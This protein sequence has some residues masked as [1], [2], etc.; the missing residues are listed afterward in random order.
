VKR[1]L[2]LGVVGA[3]AVGAALVAGSRWGARAQHAPTGTGSGAPRTE[4]EWLVGAVVRDLSELI[5]KAAGRLDG[6]GRLSVRVVQEDPRRPRAAVT[7]VDPQGSVLQSGVI[8][9]THF[10]WSP[11]DYQSWATVLLRSG[12]VVPSDSPGDDGSRLLEALLEPTAAVLHR[13]SEEVSESLGRDLRVASRHEDAAAVVGAFALRDAAGEFADTRDLL[14]RMA[15]HL[16]MARALRPGEP[17]GVTGAV[18]EA[19]LLVLAGRQAEGM[20]A[21]AAIADDAR[22]AEP[23]RSAWAAALRL[24]A[25]EDWRQA[26]AG[27][28][29]LERREHYRALVNGYDPT[30]ADRRQAGKMADEVPDWARISLQRM[31]RGPQ[32]HRHLG[33]ALHREQ[34]ELRAVWEASRSEPFDLANAEALDAVADGC[35]E[36]ADGQRRVRVLQWGD[37]ASTFQRHAAMLAYKEQVL[38]THIQDSAAAADRE[39]A[40]A[41]E[42]LGALRLFPL[43]EQRRART[44][45]EYTSAMTRAVALVTAHPEQVTFQNWVALQKPAHFAPHFP[46]VPSSDAWFVGF[47]AGTTIDGRFRLERLASLRTADLATI[48]ALRALSPYDGGVIGQLIV[49]KHPEVRT[50]ADIGRESGERRLYDPLIMHWMAKCCVDTDPALFREV[51]ARLCPLDPER[52]MVVADQ[53]ADRQTDEAAAL[54]YQ[55]AADH[56]IAEGLV[57]EQG[58]LTRYY[59]ERGEEARALKLARA[60]AATGTTEGLETL[61]RLLERMGRLQEARAVLESVKERDGAS[62]ALTQFLY[63]RGPAGHDAF[64]EST[65]EYFPDGLE[66]VTVADLHEPPGDGLLVGE[67]HENLQKGGIGI[68]NV[69]VAVDGFRVRSVIQYHLVR[70]LEVGPETDLIVWNGS[71]YR[72]VRVATPRRIVDAGLVTYAR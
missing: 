50:A 53:L 8:E 1:I 52:C 63:R 4:H 11:R 17:P 67:D 60:A 5:W 70:G 31:E 48:E 37:W 12:G 54:A 9:T 40:E 3:A 16:A 7:L 51:V 57:A 59:Y 24:R 14:S 66:A 33:G 35:L 32:A 22:L 38:W 30:H 6:G 13:E 62:D 43:I 61:G 72:D 26:P 64:V 65:R 21:I 34:E 25:T 55:G 41:R 29:L 10:V 45:Q 15:A 19:V 56:G 42:Q 23:A 71:A 39:W 36:E 27:Q 44:A 49:H 28:S 20:T 46:G 18:A 47:P 69:I 58:W 68:G 2:V